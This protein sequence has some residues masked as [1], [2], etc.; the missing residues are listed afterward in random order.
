MP[1]EICTIQESYVFGPIDYWT[2]L[3]LSSLQWGSEYQTCL[4]F[5]WLIVVRLPNGPVFE[6]HLN[7]RLNLVWYSDHHLNTGHLNTGQ[8]KFF[9]EMFPSFIC[10]LFRTPLYF[11]FDNFFNPR[12]MTSE[13]RLARLT[14]MREK[15][16]RNIK[17]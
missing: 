1:F 15:L 6:C 10:S 13:F 7:T 8:V 17:H 2:S 11:H 9:I 5:K 3:V 14:I 4:V 16:L 12:M